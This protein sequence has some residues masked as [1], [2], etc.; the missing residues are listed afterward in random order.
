[1]NGRERIR[2]IFAHEPADRVGFWLGNPLPETKEIYARALRI[3]VVSAPAVAQSVQEPVDWEAV[4]AIA[5][6]A[7]QADLELAAA[8][9]GDFFWYSPEHDPAAWRHPEGKPIFDCYGG[10]PREFLGQAGVFA[11]CED[12]GEIEEFEWPDPRYLDFSS[13]LQVID[14]VRARGMAVVS[15][16]WMP[17]FHVVADFLGMEG[18]FIKM[19]THPHV[20]EAITER[21][22]E[23]YL[24]S[25]RRFLEVAASRVDAFF[26]GNDIGSQRDLLISPA[27]FA[28][29]VLPGMK[30]VVAQAKSFGLPVML[31]S[32]GAVAKIIPSL[33]EAGIDALHPLQARASGMDALSLARRFKNDIAFVGGVD[34]QD[35]LPY[36]SASEVREEVRRLKRIFGS[37]F[38]VSP[39]HEA[40]LPHVSLDNVLAMRDAALE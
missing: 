10:K 9:G 23:F 33:I 15:G 28:R 14:L 3:E 25:N 31:H 20:V 22:L 27:S 11:N 18:Y 16:M 19:S 26:F 2:H 32:C 38:V 37:L 6:R 7:A 8:L 36:R 5:V 29:Y 13:T 34:T 35:L 17:F 39:S 40:L 4:A 24:E 1:M 21:V 12:A 30:R